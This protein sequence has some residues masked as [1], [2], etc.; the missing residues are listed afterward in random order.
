MRACS[1]IEGDHKGPHTTPG[2]PPMWLPWGG[3]GPLAQPSPRTLPLLQ[4]LSFPRQHVAQN[5]RIIMLTIMRSE[6]KGYRPLPGKIT[7]SRQSFLAWPRCQFRFI[8]TPEFRELLWIM[9]KPFT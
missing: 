6:H 3:V 5:D 7:Q 9:T 8:A 4:S 2:E 1:P